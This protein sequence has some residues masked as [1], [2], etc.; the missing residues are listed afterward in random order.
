[1]SEYEIGNLPKGE[2]TITVTLQYQTLSYG[3]AQDLYKNAE[4]PEVALMKALDSN[5]TNHY[6]T[7]STDTASITI[8]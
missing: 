7:I 1:M 5:T 6:E 8:P 4:L 2:Y 3:F